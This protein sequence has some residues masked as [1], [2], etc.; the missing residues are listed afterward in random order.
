M[1]TI[2]QSKNGMN[3]INFASLKSYSFFRDIFIQL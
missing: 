2:K 3:I 1:I